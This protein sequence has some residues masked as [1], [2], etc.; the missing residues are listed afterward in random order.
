MNG[1][2]LCDQFCHRQFSRFELFNVFSNMPDMIG[3]VTASAAYNI[4]KTFG[5]ILPGN[6]PFLPAFFI[7]AHGIPAIPH[8]I[9]RDIKVAILKAG[10]MCRISAPVQSS[11]PHSTGGCAMEV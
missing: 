8:W 7:K 5:P 9:S 11:N 10:N 3:C 4:H 2:G 6:V 1:S